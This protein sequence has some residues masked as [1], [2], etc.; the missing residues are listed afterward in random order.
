MPITKVLDS[1]G[2]PVKQDGKIK[3]IVRVNYTDAQGKYKSRKRTVLGLDEAKRLELELSTEIKK[4]PQGGNLTIYGL[5]DEYLRAKEHEV[6]KSTMIE[7]KKN[8]RNHLTSLFDIKLSKLTMPV[9]QAW[10]SEIEAKGLA[11]NTRKSIYGTLCAM[12][13]Y[14]VKMDYLPNNPLSKLGKFKA[15]LQKPKEM[16]YYTA[17]EFTKYIAA[18]REQAEQKDTLRAW[19]AYVFFNIAFFTGMRKG[20]INALTWDDVQGGFVAVT[21][22]VAQKNGDRITSPKNRSSIRRVEIPQPLQEVLDEHFA[23]CKDM[24]GFNSSLFVCGGD[25]PLRD[26]YIDN[27]NRKFAQLAGVKHIRIHDFRHSHASLLANAG[28]NIQEIARRLGHSD[29]K[30]TLQTYSH[31]YPSEAERAVKVLNEIKI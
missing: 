7:I 3:Y 18:A 10:K 30:M 16:L 8:A 1:A 12:L 29:I 14:A 5:Y 24:P 26:A 15:P 21:K 27:S 2:K 31:L 4:A 17:D 6:K 28:I 20:E 25:K 11:L 22:S 9:L 13:N 23:R 19:G